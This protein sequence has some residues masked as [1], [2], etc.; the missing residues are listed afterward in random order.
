M[1]QSA[2]THDHHLRRLR[3]IGRQQVL[4]QQHPGRNVL[5]GEEVKAEPQVVPGPDPACLQRRTDFRVTH[6]CKSNERSTVGLRDLTGPERRRGV[7]RPQLGAG[8]QDIGAP[9]ARGPQ[10]A[11][12]LIS[13]AKLRLTVGNTTND[14]SPYGGDV[15]GTTNAWTQSAVTWNTAPAA[16]PTKV[17]SVPTAVALNTSYLFDVKP[18]VTGDGTVSMLLKSTSSDGARYYS[19]ES[20]TT[21]QAPQLQVTCG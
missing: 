16:G 20:G 6:P 15:Y 5:C 4:I 21:T 13:S 10:R 1:A 8:I 14:N 12:C 18:L 9:Q 2:E 3:A 11:G 7:R 19:T 17:G